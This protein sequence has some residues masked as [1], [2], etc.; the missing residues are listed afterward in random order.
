MQKIH[1]NLLIFSKQRRRIEWTKKMYMSKQ[2]LLVDLPAP[3]RNVEIFDEEDKL[4]FRRGMCLFVMTMMV[5]MVSV[6]I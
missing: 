4:T 6:S 2:H 1:N 5:N 3:N